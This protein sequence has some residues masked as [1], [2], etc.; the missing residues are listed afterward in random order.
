MFASSARGAV[1]CV[2][3]TGRAELALPVQPVEDLPWISLNCSPI[4]QPA[5]ERMDDRVTGT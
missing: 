2:H 3:V 4:V 1:D 5:F